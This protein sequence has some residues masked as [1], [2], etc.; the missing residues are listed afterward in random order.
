MVLPFHPLAYRGDCAAEVAPA[1][2]CW[3]AMSHVSITLVVTHRGKTWVMENANGNLNWQDQAKEH[4]SKPESRYM[5][6]RARALL[7]AHNL[8]RKHPSALGVWEVFLENTFLAHAR[9][10]SSPRRGREPQVSEGE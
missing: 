5:A 1:S 2:G 9:T 8:Q 4:V 6:N 7:M 3:C 10:M